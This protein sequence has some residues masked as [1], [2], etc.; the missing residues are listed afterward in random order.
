M[1]NNRILI[2]LWAALLTAFVLWATVAHFD[3]F[4]EKKTASGLY[5]QY[6][7]RSTRPQDD[8]FRY[9]NGKWLDETEIPADK[10]AYG[11]SYETHEK[12]QKAL[13]KIIETSSS[14]NHILGSDAQLI[15]D[16]YASF[17]NEAQIE[18]LGLVPLRDELARIDSLLSAKDIPFVMARFVKIGVTAPFGLYLHQDNKDSSR[19]VVEFVQDGLGLPDRDYYLSQDTIFKTILAKYETYAEEMLARSGDK[20]AAENAKGIITIETELAK[21]QWGREDLRDPIKT[22]NKFE[23]SDLASLSPQY[24]WP[25]FLREAGLEGKTSSVIVGQPSYFAGFDKILRKVPLSALKAYFRL[26]LLS[27][28]GPYLSKDFADTRFEFYGTILA[29]VP[30]MKPR[31]ERGV[32]LVDVLVGESLGKLYVEK[33]FPQE[34]KV[35]VEKLVQNLLE[36]YRQSIDDIDWMSPETKKEAK[37]KLNAFTYKIGY[38][39]RWRDYSLLAIKIKKDELIGNVMSA[40]MFE[41]ERQIA[42]LGRPVDR[43]EWHMSPQ[44]FNAYYNPEQNEIVFPAGILQPPIFDPMADDAVN[45]GSI[46]VIIGH[47]ISHGFDD[48]GSQYDGRGN[49]RNWWT[50]QDHENFTKKTRALV[51]QYNAYEPVKGYAVNGAYTLGE[52]IAD[53]SGVAIALKAYHLSLAGAS[54]PVLDGFT[55]EQRFYIGMAQSWRGKVR[56]NEEIIR[57]KSDPHSPSKFRVNGSLANQPEFYGAFGVKEEDAMYLPPEKRISIW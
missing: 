48:Q 23:F 54:S 50:K 11:V 37:N 28:Y 57:I 18:K 20:N 22:Y 34:S 53:N 52:N 42:K 51:E 5:V 1:K 31:W 16:L 3:A 4:T 41:Y 29:G 8:F 39:E 35:R 38:P 32:S 21:I 9:V 47:E 33:Y 36:A 24:D 27:S 15:G 14:G 44:T 49:L 30:K 43:N 12:T 56:D 46:G 26:H 6:F 40:N 2:W 17:M 10:I 13:L 19:Y 7:D 55:G 25:A 45:Y